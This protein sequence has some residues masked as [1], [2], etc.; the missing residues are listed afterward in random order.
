MVAES[1]R[2]VTSGEMLG[3]ILLNYLQASRTMSWPGT[4]GLTVDDILKCYPLAS[5]VG[6]VPDYQELCHRHPGLIAEIQSLFLLKDW[7]RSR[8]PQ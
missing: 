7:P 8:E 4:D 5:A 3:Q 2:G 6:E 1:V